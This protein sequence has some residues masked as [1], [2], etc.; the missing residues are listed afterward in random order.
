MWGKANFRKKLCLD[1][2]REKRYNDKMKVQEKDVIRELF[3]H[4]KQKDIWAYR[5]YYP[6]GFLGSCSA[7]IEFDFLR[8][9]KKYFVY[10]YEIKLS[11]SDFRAEKNKRFKMEL[12]SEGR[13]P[14]VLTYVMPEEVY[15]KVSD[16]IPEACGVKTFIGEEW[17]YLYCPVT[18]FLIFKDIKKPSQASKQKIKEKD[19]IQL[20]VNQTYKIQKHL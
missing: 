4:F 19:L 18:R 9:T 3:Y 5:G 7:W 8:I 13:Y 16:E 15:N 6:A 17:E 14:A 1:N 12:I 10:E 20:L 2:I 11:V